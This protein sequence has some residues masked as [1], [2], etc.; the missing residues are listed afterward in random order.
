MSRLLWFVLGGIATAVGTGIATV[1]LDEGQEGD[2]GM[3]TDVGEGANTC[4]EN[5][6]LAG[7]DEE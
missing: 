7:S 2:S 4:N 5:E 1:M 6:K 3:D